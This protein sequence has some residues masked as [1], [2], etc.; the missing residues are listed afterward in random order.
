MRRD[1]V[2]KATISP[3]LV[4]GFVATSLTAFGVSG[5]V[6]A[7]PE[8]TVFAAAYLGADELGETSLPSTITV[9]GSEKPVTWSFDSETFAAPYASVQVDGTAGGEPVTADVEVLPP[10]ENPLVYFVD[11]GHNG[12]SQAKSYSNLLTDSHSYASVSSLD[13]V[14]LHNTTPDL[15]YTAGT[16]DWGFL[17]TSTNNYKISTTG[18]DPNPSDA[19]TLGSYGKYELG[20]R[21]NGTAISYHLALAPGTY[22]LS[23]GFFEFYTGS[24]A[25]SRGMVPTIS[26]TLDGAPASQKLE[27]AI[28]NTPANTTGQLLVTDAFTIPDG[29]SDITL[30]YV[31]SSGEAPCISWFSIAAGDVEKTIDD[32]LAVPVTATDITINADD[33][34]ADNLNGLTFKGFGVLSANSTSALLM[35]YKS[36]HPQQYAQL[37][38]VLFGGDHP[39][40][41]QV[42][43]EMGNDRNNS[44]GPDVATMRTATEPANVRRDPSFQL[45]ADAKKLNPDLRVSILRWNAP[46]WANNNDKIYTWYKNTILA[47]YRDYGY[48]VDYVNP[49]VN[50]SAA[51][52][53]WTK[54]F[55]N[56]V[57]TDT[58]GYASDD[59]DLAGFRPGEADLFHNIKTVISDEVGVGSFGNAIMSDSALRDAVSVAG[60]HYNT[61]DDGAGNFK[62][63]AQQYDKEVWNSEAQATF[64][65]SSFRQ[66][67]TMTDPTVEGT[68]IGG[69]GGPLE[70]ANTIVKGFVE[71]NRTHFVYQPAIASFFEGGQYSYKALVGASD[72][73]SGWIHYDAGLAILQH[74]SDFAVTGWEDSDNSA[75]IW[76]AMP[77]ASASTAT[78]TNPVSG[79]NGLPDYITLAAPDRSDFSTVIVNDSETARTYKLKPKGFSGADGTL[80]VWETR[81][82]DDGQAFDANYKQHVADLAPS[83][84]G[85]YTLTVKPN[86]IVTVTTLD[87]SGDSSWT[88]PLPVEGERTV[89]ESDPSTGTLWSDDYDYSDLRVPVIA[90]GGGLSGAT[91]DFIASRGG[92]SGAIPLYTWDRNGAFEAVLTDDG[93]RVLRQQVDRTATGVG[94]AWNGGDPITAVGER[95]WTNY[96]AGVDVRFATAPA[97]DNYAAIGA[98]SSGG[99]NS[100]SL[101]STPYA[102][103]LRSDGAWDFLR[104]G[105][106]I[107]SGSVA[108]DGWDAAAWHRLDIRVAGDRIVGSVDGSQ[109]FSWTDP[110]PYLSGWVDLAS[111]F[112]TT[113]FDNLSIKRIADDVPSYGEY[114]DGLE[115]NDLADP[116]T[117]KLAYDGAWSHANGGGMYEYQR[118]SSTN[119]AAGAGVS[120]TFTGSGLDLIGVNN[121]TARINAYVDGALIAA[122]AP[123]QVAGQYQKWFSLRGLPWGEHTVRLEIASGTVDVDAV[124]IISSPASEAAPAT[125]V[126]TA[127]AT[128]EGIQR[129]DDFTDADWAVLQANIASARAAV[130]DAAAYR[131]D[132]EGS[133]A[134]VTRLNAASSPLAARIKSLPTITLATLV[135]VPPTGLPATMTAV[136][137]DD[138]TREVHI[139]WK[140]D[141]VDVSRPWTT[142][143]ITGS[144]GIASTTA[145]VEVV[146]RG[147][148]AFADVNGTAAALGFDSPSYAAINGLVGGTLLNESPDQVFQSG[149]TWGHF[150]RTPA[151]AMN[152]QYKGIVAGPYDKTTTTGL[153]TVNQIGATVGYT[154]TLPAGHYTIAAGSYSWWPGSSRSA[155]VL[156]DYDGASHSVDI[157]TLDT[158]NAGKVLSYDITLKDD[159]PVTLTLRGTNNQSPMLSW[160]AA[161][162][163]TYGVGYDLNGGN[164]SAPASR[165]GLLWSESGFAAD[166]DAT[167]TGFAFDGWNTAADG[168]GVAV[169]DATT[170][171]VLAEGDRSDELVTLF[172]QWKATAPQWTSFAIHL[173]GDIVIYDGRAFEAQWWT[174][175]ETPGASPYGAWAEIGSYRMCTDGPVQAWTNSAIYTG[176]ETVVVD[177]K[178]WK[179]QWWTRNQR[180]DAT[181]WG[182][183][184]QVGTC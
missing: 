35:D 106:S 149:A 51:D 50:E 9:N 109:V 152:L 115:M 80:A 52:L 67:N 178:L 40:M 34:A 137:T 123:T 146:P 62:K 174:K 118:S 69:T 6:A 4:L 15:R 157:V 159:G 64:S 104:R 21:T 132:G 49:G 97:S 5:A 72:P 94:G 172:A 138:T 57:R 96:D 155:D 179:A 162:V 151:G 16:T 128:A 47:A 42:K 71:S 7:S 46:A 168:S 171:S 11:A 140:L 120:Y 8:A 76:R 93:E 111:G 73:W 37:L 165:T 101:A 182:P 44:T 141:G 55:T 147:V 117:T 160:V 133:A 18:G 154:F 122:N 12:D 95:R 131:L 13:A 24:Q 3:A 66:N 43:I 59:A 30:S 91:E 10:A 79:R 143:T 98:R 1:S 153:Y 20:V 135:D 70:M 26:Y 107:S 158:A 180:P 134:L 125:P 113:D 56:R 22:T 114:L 164:G 183:W 63:L 31:Q 77:T 60:Y 86:S 126:A 139:T 161:V 29:A 36:Q 156:L 112:H 92:D 89:L 87:V 142:A 2:L 82:A 167:K 45:A 61:N 28:L 116:P 176:G 110:T 41:N 170:Y 100:Q 136:L 130:A 103:R 127:L 121:G 84:A 54:D 129:T 65:N 75:G 78:G 177:G 181:P 68:G 145:S 124:G 38:Q 81:G 108:G 14:T 17:T 169:S 105:A 85:T 166:A 25:R 58:T 74:F 33:I 163:G 23:S 53:A 39:I 148:K 88:T 144:Y 175:N 184:K 48:M 173:A 150:A 99:D 102:L 83:T 32:A 119:Q 27:Q 19:A 90:D